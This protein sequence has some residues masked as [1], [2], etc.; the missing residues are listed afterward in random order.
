MFSGQIEVDETFFGGKETNKHANKK[1]GFHITTAGKMPVFG[2]KSRSPNKVKAF[3]ID[4]VRQE[5]LQDAISCNVERGSEVYTDG[6]KG[7]HGLSG[8]HH[9]TVKHSVGEHVKGK[10]HTNG[11][12][13]FWAMLKHGYYGT[14]HKMSR[15]HLYRYVTEFSGRHNVR[16]L[17]TVVQMNDIARA[18][19]GKRLPYQNLIA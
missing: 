1:L 6:W 18:M 4:N 10:V 17:D 14:F 12:E 9:D 7:Y 15:K 16:R 8:Y 3:P 13:S 2:V 5:T 19:S 11:I